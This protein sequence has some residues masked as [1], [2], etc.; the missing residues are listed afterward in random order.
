M[1]L[2]SVSDYF[3][4]RLSTFLGRE[5]TADDYSIIGTTKVPENCQYNTAV[6]LY[7]NNPRAGEARSFEF[8]YDR[9]HVGEFCKKHNVFIR[10]VLTD[11]KAIADLFKKLTGLDLETK[12]FYLDQNDQGTVMNFNESLIFMGEITVRLN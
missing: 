9:I 12:D 5:V 1:N 6:I 8:Y 10:S 3:Y 4:T 7:A 11:K 2:N